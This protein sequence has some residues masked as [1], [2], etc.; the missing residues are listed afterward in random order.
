MSAIAFLGFLAGILTT[1]AFVPQVIRTWQLRSAKDFSLG[2]LVTFVSGIFLWLIYGILI[3]S[4][5]VI[6]ANFFTFIL[7]S[8]I[9]WFKLRYK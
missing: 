7:A 9:L 4:W 3:Q 6:I 1:V 8:T 2:M 5:P